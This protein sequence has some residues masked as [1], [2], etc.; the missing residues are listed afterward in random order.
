MFK[1]T[2]SAFVVLVVL[3]VTIFL[4]FDPTGSSYSF[5]VN[6]LDCDNINYMSGC[7]HEIGHKMDDE[8]NMPSLS[9]EFGGAVQLYILAEMKKPD[10]SAL[11]LI[12]LTHPG[13]YSYDS[14][15]P[16]MIQREVYASIYA[17]AEG[18]I[19]LIPDIFKSF[20]S[21]DRSYLDLYECLAQPGFN[22]CN[23][24]NISNMKG[25]YNG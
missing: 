23:G 8:L 17:W 21:T 1:K 4:L 3:I 24:L 7:R 5:M 6:V 14:T 22:V 18:D 15:H 10:T 11:A 20:Y 13:V 19:N 2:T 16:I 12:I 25:E 9:K